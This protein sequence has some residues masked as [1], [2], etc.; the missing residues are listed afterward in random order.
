MTRRARG[1]GEGRRRS[2]RGQDLRTTRPL[3]GGVLLVV[4]GL[5][6]IWVDGHGGVSTMISAS[7]GSTPT[8]IGAALVLLGVL[9]WLT[10]MYA[11][12]IGLWALAVAVLSF[13]AA[14]LGGY[15]IG[16]L[17]GILGGALVFAWR[18]DH[19]ITHEVEA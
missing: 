4:G 1:A 9:A 3:L 10:P 8:L 16:S 19:I 18:T 12:I 11:V 14:N 13:V 2:G 7:G 6:I 17:L 15:L 5:E